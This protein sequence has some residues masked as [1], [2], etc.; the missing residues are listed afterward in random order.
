MKYLLVLVLLSL[1]LFSKD[2]GSVLYSSCKYC[3][4]I[5]AD[6]TYVDVVL[7]IKAMDANTL[8]TK[9]RL[10]KK[11]EIDIYGYGAIMRQQMKNI[12]D[13]KISEL[14]NYIKTL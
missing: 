2:E 4:G 14:V 7:S 10:Y 9:L 11:G 8:E 13:D 5:K 3:H 6:K 12:P 1:S